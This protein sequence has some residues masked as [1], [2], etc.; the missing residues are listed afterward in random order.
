MNN[1]KNILI[2]DDEVGIV[3]MLCTILNKEGFNDVDSA[4]TGTE[5][6]EKAKNN[7]YD[8]ILL[9][10]M[11]PDLDGFQVCSFIREYSSAPILFL[12]AKTSDIDKL[13]G[14][15]IGG[16]D[17]ITKPF[18][19]LEVVARIQVQFRRMEQFAK[20]RFN[21]THDF[22]HFGDVMVDKKS[23]QLWVND[24]EVPCPAKEFELLVYLMEHPNQVFT[25][26]QLYEKIW[27]FDSYGDEKTV[28]VHIGRIRRKIEK[29]IKNPEYIINLRGIGYK[30]VGKLR[31]D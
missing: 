20:S 19:P 30:F 22:F 18:N 29:D 6:I 24:K 15:R 17:Y 11:L 9:D 12:T 23:A 21:E 4:F 3:K 31:G 14:L 7:K 1:R 2:V 8:L 26:S 5:A 10:V 13:T 25:A 28:S 16:D 27:G